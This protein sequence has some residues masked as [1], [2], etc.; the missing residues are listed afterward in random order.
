M[1]V[2]IGRID[3]FFFWLL[4]FFFFCGGGGG[5]EE[6]KKNKTKKT[7]T[8]KK[9]PFTMNNYIPTPKSVNVSRNKIRYL[10]LFE[11]ILFYIKLIG[12]GHPTLH[13]VLLS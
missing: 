4:C 12:Y 1:Y 3:D 2:C 8:K 11:M 9:Q 6:A 10:F 7:K 13:F 5:G